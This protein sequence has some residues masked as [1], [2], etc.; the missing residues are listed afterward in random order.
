M[1]RIKKLLIYGLVFIL[2]FQLVAASNSTK[3]QITKV[4]VTVDGS[5]D[6]DVN[7][8]G[9]V[10]KDLKPGSSVKVKVRV[11]NAFTTQENLDI[12]NI[13]ISGILE[14]IDDG[15]DLEDESNEFDLR[16]VRSKTETLTYDI[17]QKVDDGDY[18]LRLTVE[19]EDENSTEYNIEQTL[20]LEV[21]KDKHAIAIEKASLDSDTLDC[22][23]TTS[24]NVKLTNYGR[25][26]EDKVTL[27]IVNSALGL[28]VKEENLDLTEDLFSDDSSYTKVVAIKVPDTLKAEIYPIEISVFYDDDNLDDTKTVNLEVED[29]TAVLKEKEA[30]AEDKQAADKEKTDSE[31][32]GGFE[33]VSPSTSG[34]KEDTFTVYAAPTTPTGQTAAPA[35]DT[36]EKGTSR[37]TYALIAAVAVILL[38]VVVAALLGVVLILRR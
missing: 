10:G 19:G 20:I 27:Q 5:S 29:C 9:R 7:D 12:N 21:K 4:D 2:L 31:E 34:N 30:A 23:R 28:N 17:P 14:S 18:T 26:E 38:L 8:G 22:T 16:P 33:I 11:D 6:K 37:T 15:E 36:A 3:L 1:V 32:S 13:I 24:L 25:D 35:L